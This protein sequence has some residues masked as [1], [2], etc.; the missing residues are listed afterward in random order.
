VTNLSP[1]DDLERQLPQ[2]VF[3][4]TKDGPEDHWARVHIRLG[5]WIDLSKVEYD[6]RQIE[7]TFWALLEVEVWR[8][9]V[10]SLGGWSG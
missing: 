9:S 10:A 4:W 1:L 2:G 8:E 6:A 3:R 7:P 5:E